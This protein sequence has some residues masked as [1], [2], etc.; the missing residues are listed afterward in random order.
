MPEFHHMDYA[1]GLGYARGER[2]LYASK[3]SY[4]CLLLFGFAAWA[5]DFH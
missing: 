5:L 4:C 2:F 1:G 3:I